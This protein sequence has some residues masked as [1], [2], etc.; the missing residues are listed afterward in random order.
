MKVFLISCFLPKFDEMNGVEI[1]NF[2][3][4]LTLEDAEKLATENP[5]YVRIYDLK[6]FEWAV[7]SENLYVT[8]EYIRFF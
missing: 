8:D 4:D 2:I 6:E 7:N 3:C 5:D 1:L